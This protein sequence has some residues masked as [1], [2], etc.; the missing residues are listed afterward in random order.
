LALDIV[1]NVTE[2]WSQIDVYRI[3][4]SND[5]VPSY[6]KWKIIPNSSTTNSSTGSNFSSGAEYWDGTY[7]ITSYYG[8]SLAV[9]NGWSNNGTDIVQY[10]Y[11]GN[12]VLVKQNCNSLT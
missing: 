3:S 2:N 10:D 12:L 4:S 6:C 9:Y 1:S 11:L 7:R 5:S 8:K